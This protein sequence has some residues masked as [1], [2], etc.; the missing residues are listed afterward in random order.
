MQKA[1][2]P[3]KF[4]SSAPPVHL[5]ASM[6]FLL[7]LVTEHLHTATE[8]R[9]FCLISSGETL[10]KIH[11]YAEG[12]WRRGLKQQTLGKQ[13]VF[14]TLHDPSETRFPC[15]TPESPSVLYFWM[16]ISWGYQQS[17]IASLY[18]IWTWQSPQTSL[19]NNWY[20]IKLAMYTLTKVA[21]RYWQSK[22]S[23]IPPCPGIVLAK[24]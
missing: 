17:C 13:V 1:K 22:R 6:G 18:V 23:M 4:S 2:Q 12:T 11:R 14:P 15:S 5:C 20:L 7:C 24:S 16:L 3:H 8:L 9:F 21:I 19:G 10:F